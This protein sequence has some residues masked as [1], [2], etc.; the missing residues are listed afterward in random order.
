MRYRLDRSFFK[1]QTVFE[2]DHIN[3]K[4]ASNRSKGQDDIAH[5]E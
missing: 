2:A 3:A 1:K 4:K 5:L